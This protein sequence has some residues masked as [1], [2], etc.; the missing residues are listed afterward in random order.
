MFLEQFHP[1]EDMNHIFSYIAFFYIFI[2]IWK[3]HL[4][5]RTHTRTHPS[6]HTHQYYNHINTHTNTCTSTCTSTHTSVYFRVHIFFLIVF[7]FE[8]TSVYTVTQS[9]RLRT[10]TSPVL[11][12]CRTCFSVYRTRPHNLPMVH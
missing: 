8:F 5:T 6:Q 9:I 10:S 7:F 3:K 2:I 11:P 4:Y 12:Y 1:H